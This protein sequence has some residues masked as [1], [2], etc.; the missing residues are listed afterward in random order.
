MFC[1]C[2]I[3]SNA[4]MKT[5]DAFMDCENMS[6]C[7]ESAN[8]CYNQTIWFEFQMLLRYIITTSDFDMEQT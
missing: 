6:I 1:K 4:C 7:S 3:K 8:V 5:T 2:H